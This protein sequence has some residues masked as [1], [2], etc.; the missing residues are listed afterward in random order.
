MPCR[1]TRTPTFGAMISRTSMKPSVLGHRALC[2][3]PTLQEPLASQAVAPRFLVPIIG[4]PKP[5]GPY[6]RV[7]EPTA[8]DGGDAVTRSSRI[9]S[10]GRAA[11]W[12]TRVCKRG[13]RQP[14]RP[15]PR[16][17]HDGR[18]LIFLSVRHPVLRMT[19]RKCPSIYL[20]AGSVQDTTGTPIAAASANILQLLA[21]P[22]GFE[23]TL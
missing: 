16:P 14:A 8:A 11:F 15:R 3:K 6:G 18:R 5:D 20:A 4:G 23:P 19:A 22:R 9:I 21:S 2:R 17:R 1:L 12:P 7:Y 10:R 13:G